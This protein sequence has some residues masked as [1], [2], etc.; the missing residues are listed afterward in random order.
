MFIAPV[1]RLALSAAFGVSLSL[2]ISSPA[3][4]VPSAR[5]P[6]EVKIDGQTADWAASNSILDAR[7]GAEFA[8][9]NDGRFLYVLFVLRK[10]EARASL[11]ST[12]I[13]VL[14]GSGNAKTSK[15]VLFL[16]RKVPVETYIR[17]HESQGTQLTEEEK[18]R[19]RADAQRDLC[20]AF[21]VGER[22][23]IFGPLRRLPES[24]PPECA[25][26]EDAT[27]TVYELKIP[28]A[29]SDLV[30]GGLGASPGANVSLSFAWGGA[31]RRVLSTKT[32]REASALEQTGALAGSGVTWAQ[33]FLDTF[34]S[35]SRPTMG[36]KAF[37]FAVDV[38]L[39][40]AK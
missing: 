6:V 21:A 18:A 30:P 16:K 40:E 20:L 37:S 34:D 8:F 9:Q 39:T 10:P 38:G 29:S 15:G 5:A 11:E 4:V 23:S 19:L 17:W 14:A 25:V 22:G 33:E 35:M 27:K 12:G 31:S 2:P 32:T 26:S 36:T 28:L 7:S 13:T 1:L 24:R 3:Q